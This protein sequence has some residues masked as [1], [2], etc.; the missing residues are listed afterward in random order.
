[1]MAFPYFPFS[2]ET[3]TLTMGTAPLHDRP[4]I[5]LDRDCYQAE[6]A[7]KTEILAHDPGYYFQAHPQTEAMQWAVLA[8]VLRDLARH[9]P[10]EFSLHIAGERWAWSNRL[11]DLEL[12]FRW[13]DA[14][15][16]PLAPLDWVGRQVQEDLL[17]MADDGADFPLVAGQ[18]CFGGNWCLDDKLGRS[19]LDIHHPVPRFAAQLGRPSQLLLTRLKA[20]RPVWRVNWS[21][22]AGNRLNAAPRF[23]A[24]TDALK[25]QVTP[26]NA[27]QRCFLRVERQ[28]LSRLSGAGGLLFTIHTYLQSM[29]AL[30]AQP[31]QART[32]LGVLR[33]APPEMLDYKGMTPFV[34][35]LLAYLAARAAWPLDP[36]QEFP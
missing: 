22:T 29:A 15:S 23:R 4:L 3:Y 32:L 24:A 20:E 16:L 17:V 30:S 19:F 8:L 31:A 27:G 5:E 33:T 2:S 13:G 7:L 28:T 34:E 9:Q 36:G 12:T 11:L 14:A 21:I 6:V 10:D 25:R 35:P 26:E 1:M 18:L